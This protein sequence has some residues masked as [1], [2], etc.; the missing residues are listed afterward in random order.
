[1]TKNVVIF[2]APGAGKGTQSA[3]IAEKYG[4]KHLSTGELLR[5]EV[6]KKSEIGKQ[7][8]SY[9]SHGNLVPDEVIINMLSSVLKQNSQTAGFIF[10]GFPRTTAQAA[11]LKTMLKIHGT[12]VAVMLNLKVGEDELIKRLL[13]RGISSGRSD[14]NYE[15]IQHRIQVYHND[16]APVKDFYVKEGIA[17]DIDGTGSLNDI[18][19]R[20]CAAMDALA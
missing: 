3:M 2:G 12:E 13:Y 16:T 5:A 6:E 20:I 7:I 8:D 9:I 4:L 1:M 17:V 14:D 11:A 18:F 19:K 10:D 15:T